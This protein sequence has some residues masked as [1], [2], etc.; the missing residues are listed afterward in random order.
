MRP[1]ASMNCG[2]ATRT[3]SLCACMWALVDIIAVACCDDLSGSLPWM[4]HCFGQHN[5]LRFPCPI[6]LCGSLIWLPILP[7]QWPALPKTHRKRFSDSWEDWVR[8]VSLLKFLQ[9][10][11]AGIGYFQGWFPLTGLPWNL[12]AVP[13]I[14]MGHPSTFDGTS[15]QAH[16]LVMS[17]KT[18]RKKNVLFF[19]I[20]HEKS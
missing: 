8:K 19:L 11:S 13:G 2:V 18:K 5:N 15:S 6:E 20:K 17:L 10:D 14:C 3:C 16:Q 12:P 1:A 4:D 7:I 9:C